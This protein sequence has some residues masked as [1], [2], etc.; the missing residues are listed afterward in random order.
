MLPDGLQ[1]LMVLQDRDLKKSQLEKVLAGIPRER[2]A[3]ETRVAS[4]R[5]AIETA[6]KTVTEHELKRKELESLLRSLEEQIQRY[7]NQQL[8]VKKNDEYQALTHEIE[9][10]G[11]RIGDVE[12]KE[13]ELLYE[14]DT[15]R[16]D[17]R[18]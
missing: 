14:L 7:R 3:V 17:A 11:G 18:E 9:L 12:E 13:I 10:T 6:K 16:A 5:E 1:A 4:H 8:Q 2:A 15:A